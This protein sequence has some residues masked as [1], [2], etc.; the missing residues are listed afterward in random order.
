[1]RPFFENGND[2]KTLAELIPVSRVISV[3]D[4][5]IES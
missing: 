3:E 1:M 5:T 2:T 4:R